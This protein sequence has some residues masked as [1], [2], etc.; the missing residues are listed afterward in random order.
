MLQRKGEEKSPR[1]MNERRCV[2]WIKVDP[3]TCFCEPGVEIVE[4]KNKK[5]K[6]NY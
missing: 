6:Q 3:N 4:K 1:D 5:Q 2:D